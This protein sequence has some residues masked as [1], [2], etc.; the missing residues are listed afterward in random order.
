MKL[1]RPFCI[2]SQFGEPETDTAEL[3]AS[4]RLKTIGT[5]KSQP[6]FLSLILPA[7]LV[8]PIAVLGSDV[9]RCF[10]RKRQGF[11]QTS[12]NPPVW[13]TAKPFGFVADVYVDSVD[14]ISNA[15]IALPDGTSFSLAWNTNIIF[16]PTSYTFSEDFES[17]GS[18]DAAYPGGVDTLSI[19]TAHEGV[20]TITNNLPIVSYS[21]A[22]WVSNYT[23]AQSVDAGRDFRLA[24][25]PF[26]DG[27]TND[28]IIVELWHYRSPGTNRV[29]STP[30]DPPFCG[31]NTS[32]LIPENTL[33]LVH[34]L[35]DLRITAGESEVTLSWPRPSDGFVLQTATNLN[36]SD[37]WTRVVDTPVIL[38]DRFTVSLPATNDARFYRLSRD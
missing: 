30:T 12:T 28:T 32:V 3:H 13:R 23:A 26:V 22:P 7:L 36:V 16:R 8:C 38:D 14:A 19:N 5:S 11:S 10:V 35:P 6:R 17:A 34:T 37:G 33:F 20:K 18:L 15:S 2:H 29:F 27:T 4:H 24:W 25:S 9:N 31:T 21:N 1:A